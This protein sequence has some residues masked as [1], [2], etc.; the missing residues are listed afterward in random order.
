ML[1][2]NIMMA[3]TFSEE[4]QRNVY[5]PGPSN[6]T[7]L[8]THKEFNVGSEGLHLEGFSTPIGQPAVFYRDTDTYKIS[9][10]LKSFIKLGTVEDAY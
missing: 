2:E 9:E 6:W 8:W 5:L 1:G 10:V 7:Y 4:G 3:P